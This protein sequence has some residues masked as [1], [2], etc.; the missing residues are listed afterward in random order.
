MDDLD[1]KQQR[2]LKDCNLAKMYEMLIVGIYIGN[3][4]NWNKRGTA[5]GGPLLFA[6]SRIIEE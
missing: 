5:G 1:C 4:G 6:S 2:P 3:E